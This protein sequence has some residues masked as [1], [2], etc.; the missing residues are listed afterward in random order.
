[1]KRTIKSVGV[2]SLI[3]LLL[4]S[5]ISV[6][7]TTIN[8]EKA[9]L[10][11]YEKTVN[12]MCEK[13]LCTQKCGD[14]SINYLKRLKICKD[15][16]ISISENIKKY[17]ECDD[18]KKVAEVIIKEEKEIN[19]KVEKLL[20]ELEKNPV[21]DKDK[22]VEYIKVS[23]C[24][25]KH[26]CDKLVKVK[27]SSQCIDEVYL[28]AMIVYHQEGINFNK[29]ILRLTSEEKICKL[30]KEIECKQEEE[31]NLIKEIMKN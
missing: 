22:E 3:C 23:D 6:S 31:I 7:A 20:K 11:R 16:V 12:K 4:F 28:K 24:I 25:T 1:M 15:S 5:S 2:V 18:V 17:S 30:I 9:F 13:M 10:K 8:K 29:N 27:D 26:L 14:I 21:V 19:K